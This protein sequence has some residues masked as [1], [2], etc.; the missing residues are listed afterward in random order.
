MAHLIYW[1]GPFGFFV[2]CVV[3]FLYFVRRRRVYAARMEDGKRRQHV[4]ILGG[5]FGGA[6]TASHLEGLMGSRDDFEI[7]L[8][9]S[10]NYMTFQP[11]M[12]DVISGQ[13]GIVDTIAPLRELCPRTNLMVREVESVDLRNKT[14]TL[15]S[16]FTPKPSVLQYDHLVFAIGNVT[17]FRGMRGLAE[18]ALPFKTLVDALKIRNHAIATLEEAAANRYDAEL[19]KQ[20]LTFVVAGGGFSGVEC[21]AELNDFVRH[22]AHHYPT[23]DSREI[24]VVLLH[25]GDLI[26]PELAPKL[27]MYAQEILRKRGVEIRLKTKLSA[28][29][30][31]WAI[32]DT[33]EKIPTRTLIST[34]PAFP[35]PVIDA[36]TDLPKERGKIKTDAFSQVEGT[37]HLWA[38]GDCSLHPTKDH[39]MSPPTAQHAMRQGRT[40]AINIVAAIRGTKREPFNF[41]GL[42]KM[43]SLGHRCAVAEVFGI[44]LSGFFA[45][46]MWRNIYLS[47][48]PGYT[49]KVRTAFSWFLID[50]I[51]PPDLVQLKLGNEQQIAQ[52]H[53][54]E[55]E[56]V[57]RQGDVGDRI[58][59]ILAGEAD[60]LQ[61]RDGKEEICTK[62]HPG[63]FFGEM[64]L[65]ENSTR[66]A[67]VRSTGQL[68]VLSI[69]RR[70]F[71]LL[72]EH[73]TELKNSFTGI[74]ERRKLKDIRRDQARAR[75]SAAASAATPAPDMDEQATIIS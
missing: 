3:I 38:L 7:T 69:P 10:E 37:N 18:H 16:G 32:L 27:G 12:P 34:V 55:G 26:L 70:D 36:I 63:E 2:L 8:V 47:K 59:I 25:A 68:D 30:A 44:K 73:L 13:V 4:V 22:V 67:T 72:A 75:Q 35:H 57:F 14:V 65:L 39:G 48:L 52:E 6:F 71:S 56:D 45:W 23:L 42:G 21:A 31:E 28:A 15:S 58:Y 60:V 29:T 11:M 41:P 1:L 20:L 54:E 66:N 46:F 33:G 50:F 53:F 51:L 17:D 43:A 24:R 61:K 5:G 64:A 9:S 74:A 62:L 49:R 40:C 19:R